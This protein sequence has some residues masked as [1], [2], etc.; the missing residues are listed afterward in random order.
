MSAAASA[1]RSSRSAPAA[2]SALAAVAQALLVRVR[3]LSDMAQAVGDRVLAAA[4]LFVG[5]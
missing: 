3:V 1:F 2:F 5:G 4:L